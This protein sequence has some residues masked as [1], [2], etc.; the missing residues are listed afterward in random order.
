MIRISLL[1]LIM[2]AFTMPLYAQD[3][4]ADLGQK[5]FKNGVPCAII[6]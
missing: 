1:A 6:L 4:A 5:T 3:T 2:T